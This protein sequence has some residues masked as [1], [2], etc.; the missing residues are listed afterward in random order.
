[1]PLLPSLKQKKRYVVFEIQAEESFSLQEAEAA[2]KEG[3]LRFLGEF[4][5]AK[6]G[7][8]FIREKYQ[9]NKFILKINNK[10]VAEVISA[11]ILIK[12]IKNKAVI[13]RSIIT[14]GTLKKANGYVEKRGV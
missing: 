2:V 12:S 10:Y 1:M 7:P 8:M 4:G 14:S 13:L 6:A 5:V 11:I 9:P 3:L